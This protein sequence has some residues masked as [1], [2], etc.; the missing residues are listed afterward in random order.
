MHLSFKNKNCLTNKALNCTVKTA[1]YTVLVYKTL[2]QRYKNKKLKNPNFPNIYFSGL[3]LHKTSEP[4]V[5]KK[6]I[7]NQLKLGFKKTVGSDHEMAPTSECC[8][9]AQYVGLVL[10]PAE[11]FNLRPW[12]FLIVTEEWDNICPF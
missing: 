5:C 1:L 7:I 8:F 2:V 12:I 9:N 10:A 4:I 6:K 3:F 11:G